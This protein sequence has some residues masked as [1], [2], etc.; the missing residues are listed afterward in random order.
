MSNAD[1][2]QRSAV[3]YGC[4]SERLSE[5]ERSF[6]GDVKPLGFIL[7]GRNCR[8][9]QQVR[10]LVDELRATVDDEA[11]PIL[12]DQEGGRVQR[13]GPPHWNS[14]P[15]ARTVGLLDANSS[16][17]AGEAAWL[18]GRLIA[19]DLEPLGISV[20][21]APV[22]DLPVADS[23][24]VIGDRAFSTNAETVSTLGAAYCEGLL[25]GGVLPVIKHIPGHGRARVDSHHD[26][27]IVAEDINTLRETDFRPFE[28]LCSMPLAMTAHILYRG[29]DPTNVATLSPHIVA[30]VI[31]REIGFE[32]LLMSDDISMDAL[33]G[34]IDD[35]T[36][37]A[38]D[39]GCD[40][41]LH[42]NGKSSEMM[43]VADAARTLAPSA[44]KRWRAAQVTRRKT[45]DFDLDAARA[46][47]NALIS[48]DE[49]RA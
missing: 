24:D 16:A 47:L 13:L 23:H 28:A 30:E 11:A 1:L 6:F 25:D 45:R 7:F 39:A 32:G 20:S 33:P 35:R 49:A 5:A 41:V 21:C 40:V 34:R 42:C 36:R 8:D 46:R 48:V 12:I 17:A 38:L 22:I 19:A 27:P 9:P 44:I 15:A 10:G 29:L 2:R 31:R 26:L 37:A 3:I 14:L 43:L 18:V 4:L